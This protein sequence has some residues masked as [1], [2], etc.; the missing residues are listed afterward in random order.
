MIT[1]NWAIIAIASFAY[2]SLSKQE[3]NLSTSSV[4]LGPFIHSFSFSMLHPCKPKLK[5][6]I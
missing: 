6:D 2:A 1:F 3:N 5:P 4:L